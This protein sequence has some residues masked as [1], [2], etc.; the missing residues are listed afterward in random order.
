VAD[1]RPFRAVRYARPSAAVTAPPYDVIDD[2]SREALAARDQHNVVWLT[3]EPDEMVAAERVREWLADRTLVRDEAPAVWW[4]EQDAVG[5]D[6]HPRTREGIVASLRAEPYSTGVVLPHELTHPGPIEGRLRLLRATRMQLESIFVLY[7]GQAP[8]PRPAGAPDIDVGEARLWRIEGDAGVTSFF[9]DAQLLIADG[10]HRYETAVAFAQE[11]GADRLPVVLV[12]TSDAGLAVFPT[13]RVFVGRR[14]IDPPGERFSTLDEAL[15][16]LD[17]EPAVQPVAVF[18]SA[19]EARLVRAAEGELD[20]DFVDRFGHD[21]LSYTPDRAEAERRVMSGE[22]DCAF[23]LRA[24]RIEDVFAR[25]R[26]GR[27][28]PP[29]TTYFAPKLVS[30][31]LFQ[32][33]DP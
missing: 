22:A 17:S 9:M 11:D 18:L 21:G 20:V 2:A 5:P 8:L 12:S 1:V 3:L 27:P 23:V 29:K 6:A 10:H 14:D 32:P 4:I 26:V 15:A 31:L 24:P 13:H 25:A 30:G 28:M 33:V 7:E 19:G 16:A